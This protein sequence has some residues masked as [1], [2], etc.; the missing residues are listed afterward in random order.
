LF[1]IQHNEVSIIDAKRIVS[2]AYKT[3]GNEE[4]HE[5]KYGKEE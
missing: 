3:G 5:E 2:G 4:E 1:S